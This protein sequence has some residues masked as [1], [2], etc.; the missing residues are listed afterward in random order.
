[1]SIPVSMRT[2]LLFLLAVT[3]SAAALAGPAPA[4][5]AEPSASAATNCGSVRTAGRMMTQIRAS[6]VP[7]RKALWVAGRYGQL[8][9][10]F[11]AVTRPKGYRC[12]QKRYRRALRVFCTA[13]SGRG[14]VSFYDPFQPVIGYSA[15]R[16]CGST[17]SRMAD[18]R[19]IRA[20]AVSCR[21]A[22][23]LARKF[24]DSRLSP[25]GYVCKEKLTRVWTIA[26]VT[27]ST[28]AKRVVFQAAWTRGMPLPA[29]PALPNAGA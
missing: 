2:R 24:G 20:T 11:R 23:S 17:R 16:D 8:Y 1:M 7:C 12:T 27:C 28:G 22:K 13:T 15:T 10:P 5:A 4:S 29:A 18:L 14:E 21:T 26:T 3:A 19:R 25:R 9:T 6:G